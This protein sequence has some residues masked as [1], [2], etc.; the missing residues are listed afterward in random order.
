[1]AE[2]TGVVTKTVTAFLCANCSRPGQAPDSGGRPRPVVPDFDWP[3]AVDEILVPCTGR[4][5]P[6]HVLKAFEAGSDL[7]LTISCDEHNCQYRQGSERWARRADFV[8]SI[9]DEIGLGGHRLMVFKMPGT[10]AQ[11]CALGAGD[12]EPVCGGESADA[13][14]ATIRQ[15]VRQALGEVTPNPL[16]PPSADAIEE[17][18]ELYQPVDTSDEDND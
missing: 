14:I 11:D 7:V 17:E 9:L 1:M 16:S 10:S 13:R 15:T 2:A 3:F 18:E 6:E 12:A 5:Q 8:R 4:L